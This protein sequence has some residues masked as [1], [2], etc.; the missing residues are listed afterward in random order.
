VGSGGDGLR[1]TRVH[2]TQDPCEVAADL[3]LQITQSANGQI[4]GTA[5]TGSGSGGCPFP[6][7]GL[8][9]TIAGPVNGSSVTLSWRVSNAGFGLDGTVSGNRMTGQI[10][11]ITDDRT[12]TYAGTWSVVRQ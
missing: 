2:S 1:V 7:G 12:E 6:G 10:A 4:T 3:V 8:P 9:G 11:G 5:T